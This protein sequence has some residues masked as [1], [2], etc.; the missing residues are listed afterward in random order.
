MR[1]YFGIR[2]IHLLVELPPKYSIMEVMNVLKGVTARIARRDHLAEI[3]KSLGGDSFWSPSYYASTAGGVTVET[4][5]EYVASQQ[6]P[7]HRT[8]Q[9]M[10]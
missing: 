7:K 10:T 9:N 6:E 1:I 5:K 2:H 8:K 3:R 4:L